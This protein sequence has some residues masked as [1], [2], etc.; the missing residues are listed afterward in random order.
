MKR[1]L[2][3]LDVDTLPATFDR[4]VALDAGADDVISLGGVTPENVEPLVHGAIFTRGPQDLKNTAIFVG[5]SDVQAAEKVFHKVRQTFF[6]PMSVS[7]MLDPNGSS[8]TAAAAVR[9]AANTTTLK[10]SDCLILGGTGP[11]GIR[12]AE[13]LA[14]EGA[15]VRIASRQL[16]RAES[17]AALIRSRFETAQIS[18]AEISDAGLAAA[19]DSVKVIIAAGAPGV[20][21]LTAE[22]CQ[23]I[24]SLQVAIDL[25]AVPP[26]GLAGIEAGDKATDHQGISCSGAL[27]VGGLKM[28]LHRLAIETLFSSNS[29]VLE[30]QAIYA[31]SQG[32][33]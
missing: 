9:I 16:S 27:G 21:F 32:M 1:I 5:G 28:K 4:I 14:G 15:R 30:T 10:E 3:Q 11:V 24:K 20:A 22:E 29:Q 2:L 23:S 7:V 13:L 31:L 6:G 25:N 19:V 26:L 18:P 33:K 17:A 8:T 12:T